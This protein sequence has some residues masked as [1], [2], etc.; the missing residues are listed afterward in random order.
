M[1]RTSDINSA[2][3]QFFINLADNTFLDN[4]KR[5]FGYA[6]FG[7]VVKGTEV[8]DKIAEA[9]TGRSG[10]HSDVPQT[11]ITINSMKKAYPKRC[12]SK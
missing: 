3:C 6:V 7:K 10:G 2:T 4:G 9:K 1:A 12:I 5:D 8:V 11:A